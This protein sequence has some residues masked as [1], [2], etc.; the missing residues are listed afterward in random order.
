[1]PG[2]CARVA[3]LGFGFSYRQAMGIPPM[4]SE[5]LS[6]A[7][8]AVATGG[9]RGMIGA[10]D[11]C[12]E[13]VSGRRGDPATGDIYHLRHAPPRAAASDDYSLNSRRLR[14]Y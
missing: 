3:D 8:G 14:R 2:L 5:V 1:M 7:A 13:R 6:A 12:A 10:D 4:W 9:G 11:A